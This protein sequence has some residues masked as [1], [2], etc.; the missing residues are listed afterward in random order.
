MAFE[1]PLFKPAAFKASADLSAKQF[2]LVEHTGTADTVG[3]CDNAADVP[4]GVL[5]NKPAAAGEAAEVA[6]LGIAKVMAGGAFNPGA[7]VGTDGNGKAIAKTTDKDFVIGQAL[8]TGADGTI[9]AVLL[10]PCYLAV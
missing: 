8:E 1:V 7:W 2:Y 3:V 9:V 6:V 5:Q 4:I 10:R